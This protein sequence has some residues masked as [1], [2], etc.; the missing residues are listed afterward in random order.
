MANSLEARVPFLDPV[1]A[2]LALS[3][4]TRMKVKGRR[5]VGDV[6]PELSRSD[7]A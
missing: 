3:L 4:P 2:E 1:I 7:P 6:E 5:R